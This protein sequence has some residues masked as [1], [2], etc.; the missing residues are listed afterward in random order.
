MHWCSSDGD[1]VFQA[2]SSFTFRRKSEA[3]LTERSVHCGKNDTRWFFDAVREPLPE[4]DLAAYSAR[5]KQD[6]L[7]EQAM[8]KLLDKLGA[9]PW[10]DDFYRAGD[11]FGSSVLRTR[12][13]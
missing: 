12:L 10:Y 8:V 7:N 9:R 13:R 6:R 11:A 1:A 4:E 5:R 3:E 2:G